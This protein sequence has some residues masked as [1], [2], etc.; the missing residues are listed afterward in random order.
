MLRV[1]TAV[2]VTH[3]VHLGVPRQLIGQGCGIGH[4]LLEPQRQ[5]LDASCDQPAIKGGGLQAKGLLGEHHLLVPL[6][7]V[8]AHGSTEGIGVAVDVLGGAGEREGGTQHQRAL[9][10]GGG[11]GVVHH[12]G[13]AEGLGDGADRLQV[14]HLEQRVGGALQ[15][16]HRRLLGLDLLQCGRLGEVHPSGFQ[17]ELGEHLLEQPH[18]AAVEVLFAEH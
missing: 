15:P 18:G 10:Q 11:E 16:H 5:G 12:H 2:G 14:D 9:H 1:I 17:S 13:D 3:P 4:L 7:I 8:G 6:G